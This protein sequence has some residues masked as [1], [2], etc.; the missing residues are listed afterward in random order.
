LVI[1]WPEK[2][3]KGFVY[4]DLIEFSDF[5]PTFADIVGKEVEADG[6]S[7]YPLMKGEKHDPR[8]TVFVHYDPQWNKNVNQYR[9]QFVRALDYKLYRDGRFFD[10]TE[11]KLEKTPLNMDS[12]SENELKIRSALKDELKSHPKLSNN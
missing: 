8:E 7:F 4:N 5:F 9:N 11:D 12:L 1:S 2:I 3:K 10:L 6:K